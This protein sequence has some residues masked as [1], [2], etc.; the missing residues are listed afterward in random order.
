MRGYVANLPL[1][2]DVQFVTD[3]GFASAPAGRALVISLR[4]VHAQLPGFTL[5]PF[6][7][8]LWTAQSPT[9]PIDI[10]LPTGLPNGVLV[11]FQHFFAAGQDNYGSNP[12]AFEIIR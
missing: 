2:E 12:L 10:P 8:V 11:Y 4:G 1:L 5:E 3:L 6:V 9:T 7:D